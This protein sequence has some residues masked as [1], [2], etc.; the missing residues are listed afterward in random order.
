MAKSKNVVLYDY[1][2]IYIKKSFSQLKDH[3]YKVTTFHLGKP[4]EKSYTDLQKF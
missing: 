1:Q 3:E 2:F 4:P